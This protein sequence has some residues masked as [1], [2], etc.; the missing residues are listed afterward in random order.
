M[1]SEVRLPEAE[2]DRVG[3]PNVAPARW[4]R[5]SRRQC[6][7]LA[8][9]VGVAAPLA[10]LGD[11]WWQ[12]YQIR[13][14][15]HT[16]AVPRVPEPFVGLT[17]A[18]LTD[19]HHGAFVSLDY[20]REIVALTNSL[21]PDVIALAGD[22][23][24]KESRYIAPCFE[25]LAGLRAPYGVFGVLG[26]HD[27][28]QGARTTRRAL[29]AAGIVDLTNSGHWLEAGQRRFRI[30][31]VG[32]LWKGRQDLQ[33]ALGDTRP[34]ESCLLLSHNPDYAETITD[35]RVG[36]VLSGHTHGGQ[37][38]LPW[39]GA[40]HVPSHYGLKYLQG[41]VRAPVTQVFVSRG[42]G[43]VSVPLRVRC[44]PEINLLTLTDWP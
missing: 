20:V 16:L 14:T 31:G 7:K 29:S 13:V 23:T 33:A 17:V 39:I 12:T 26:N 35:Q 11:S 8:L 40:L 37:I 5:L 41:L 28:Y 3:M 10:E 22:Y 43:T 30:A 1:D 25:V 15:R 9:G 34:E 24:Y 6:L 44:P 36:L 4:G 27:H 32:D 38:V 42:L 19:L 2:W 18:L 21:A